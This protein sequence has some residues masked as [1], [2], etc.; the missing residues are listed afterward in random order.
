MKKHRAGARVIPLC[1]RTPGV[2][3]NSQGWE[4]LSHVLPFTLGTPSLIYH[5]S[6]KA[7]A[8]VLLWLYRHEKVEMIVLAG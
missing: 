8:N 2:A 4:A 7:Q 5:I 1:T 6:G 3:W